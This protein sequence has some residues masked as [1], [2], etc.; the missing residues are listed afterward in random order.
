[1]IDAKLQWVR[2]QEAWEAFWS[3]GAS[4][5]AFVQFLGEPSVELTSEWVEVGMTPTTD[6]EPPC[7]D[8][9]E[10]PW[11]ALDYRSL[12]CSARPHSRWVVL[13]EQIP[14]ILT[15]FRGAVVPL[16]AGTC[17]GMLRGPWWEGWGAWL[18][19]LYD[20]ADQGPSV[21]GVALA[22]GHELCAECGKQVRELSEIPDQAD[23]Q[24]WAR[25]AGQHKRS[26]LWVRSRAWQ[27]EV[28]P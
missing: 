17:L 10:L 23:D 18:Q 27:C 3:Q 15:A 9:A 4:C 22:F 26:C 12:A 14:S 25:I 20:R 1:M 6:N 16:R 21:S 19:S 28:E 5:W 7:A 11:S 2:E 8:W 13:V 24:A